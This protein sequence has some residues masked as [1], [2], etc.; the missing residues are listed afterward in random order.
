[1]TPTPSTPTSARHPHSH[2]HSIPQTHSNSQPLTP[3]ERIAK[4]YRLRAE[5]IHHLETRVETLQTPPLSAHNRGVS[6]RTQI[7]RSPALHSSPKSPIK[8]TTN[9]PSSSSSPVSQQK[10]EKNLSQPQQTRV[11]HQLPHSQESVSQDQDTA[12]IGEYLGSA[13]ATSFAGYIPHK[14]FIV[15]M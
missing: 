11:E 3:Q 8:P 12:L 13:R 5:Q 9:Q 1:M 10:H 2:S 15:G 14:K 6:P 7:H 4:E